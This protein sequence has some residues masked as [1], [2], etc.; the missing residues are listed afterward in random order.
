[1]GGFKF[2]VE[3]TLAA[4]TPASINAFSAAIAGKTILDYEDSY[5]DFTDPEMS[6]S[7]CGVTAFSLIDADTSSAL[8]DT[9]ITVAK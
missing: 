7:K 3:I 2:N 4:C 9:W 8:T 5:I 1:M 6:N